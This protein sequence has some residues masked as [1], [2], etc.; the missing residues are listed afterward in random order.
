[1]NKEISYVKI[2][3]FTALDAVSTVIKKE[4][5]FAPEWDGHKPCD[6]GRLFSLLWSKNK[7]MKFM[8]FNLNTLKDGHWKNN[9]YKKLENKS[10]LQKGK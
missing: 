6:I 2:V 8:K 9:N 3:R 10:K 1:M 5:E 4:L 7:E